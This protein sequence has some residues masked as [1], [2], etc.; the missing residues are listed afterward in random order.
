MYI[1]DKEIIALPI[2]ALLAMIVAG[3]PA[4]ITGILTVVFKKIYP[5]YW[6]VIS[7]IVGFISSYIWAEIISFGIGED[8]LG[9]SYGI[10][11]AIT[12]LYVSLF[13]MLLDKK[14][15]KK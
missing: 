5:Q 14:I 6:V 12:A 3:L 7:T 15:F 11:G 8:G 13:I 2:M 10:C 4:L 1:S 9:I